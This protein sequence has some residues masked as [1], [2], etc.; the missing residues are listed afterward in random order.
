MTSGRSE[1]TLDSITGR[2][3]SDRT[4]TQRFEAFYEAESERAMGLAR[5]LTTR[6][7]APDIVQESFI[8]LYK[9]WDRT[10]N[11]AGYLRRSIV[12]GAKNSYRERASHSSRSSALLAQLSS[13]AEP[14]EYLD[15][16]IASLNPKQ[17]AVVVLRFYLQL[18]DAEIADALN[19][20]RGS[21]GPTLTRALRHLRKE[22]PRET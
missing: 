11:P 18:Q 19:I 1:I 9:V 10:D 16:L 22:L 13:A 8:G 5:L 3:P 21:V 7:E 6:D 17:K 12:N 14:A 2:T 4:S 15:D 20:R